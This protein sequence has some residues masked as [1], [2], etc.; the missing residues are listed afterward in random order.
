[1]NL[2]P[3]RVCDLLRPKRTSL[4]VG[5]SPTILQ[6][7]VYRFFSDQTPALVALD[8]PDARIEQV[9]DRAAPFGHC[10]RDEGGCQCFSRS[11]VAVRKPD[12]Q[13]RVRDDS[14]A[15][16]RRL[17]PSISRC[18]S[19]VRASAPVSRSLRELERNLPGSP[20]SDMPVEAEA[21]LG[22]KCERIKKAGSNERAVSRAGSKK[23]RS[24][25]PRNFQ[26]RFFEIRALHSDGRP[27]CRC[28]RRLVFSLRR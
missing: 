27:A 17:S 19:V 13:R 28:R 16:R 10:Q 6:E 20:E 4:R 2:F 18:K 25:P 14:R 22:G 26:K 1:M 23:G 3:D 11:G 7:L 24:S 5:Q 15:S 21:L 9:P 12:R 8:G